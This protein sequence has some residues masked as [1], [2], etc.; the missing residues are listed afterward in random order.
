MG[1]K[2][3]RSLASLVVVLRATVAIVTLGAA[4]EPAR[5]GRAASRPFDVLACLELVAKSRIAPQDRGRAGHLTRHV[6]GT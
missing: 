5:L 4:I 3:S 2:P 1:N 6:T